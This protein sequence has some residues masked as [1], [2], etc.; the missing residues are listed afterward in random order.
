MQS[1][2]SSVLLGLL[3]MT[4]VLTSCGDKKEQVEKEL[5]TS[6]YQST[7]G[8]F[9]RAA[10]NGDVRALELFVK[11]DMDL[12]TKDANGWTAMHL[13]SRANRQESISFLLENGMDVDTRGL[14]GVTP[15]ML[16]AREGNT[17]MVRYLLKQGAKPEL[18]DEKKRTAL[19]LAV[20]GGHK[21]CVEEIAPFSRDQLDT[22]LLYAASK[23]KHQVI[24]TLTSFGASVYVRHEGGMTPL[25]LAAHHG[26][27]STVKALLDSGSNRYAVNEHGWTASQVAA[28]AGKDEIANLLNHDPA[29]GELTINSPEGIEG[30]E[31]MDPAPI[32]EDTAT[33]DEPT[34]VAQGS[35]QTGESEASTPVDEPTDTAPSVASTPDTVAGDSPRPSQRQRAKKL[36][37]F[38]AGKTIPSKG[39]TSTAVAKDLAMLDYKEKPL[40]LMVEKT[41]VD[42]TSSTEGAPVS[43]ASVRM[44]Y[45]KQKKVDV[46][47]GEVIPETHF[48]IVSIRRMLNHSKITD[49]QP[50]DVSVVEIEDTRTGKRREM[51]AQIPASAADPWAVLRSRSSGKTYAVRAGQKFTSAAGQHFTVTDVRPN[52]LVITHND[53]G[54]VS[55]IPLGR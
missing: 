33:E 29:D 26:L 12:N 8:D 21:S 41:G 11:H 44:L 31:W 51:T 55:T 6:G 19:I 7:P 22:A 48:K 27:A 50:A 17:T 18:K 3:G 32:T 35:E 52:Q 25:M 46:K 38:I 54:E 14:D 9:L 1:L 30:V 23:G 13:A 49:G 16:A 2:Y 43:T 42:K 15:L 40:P 10:E 45:G 34:E 4:L 20:E 28:A 53:S 24:E 47:Q 5:E 39:T 36:L 37:P